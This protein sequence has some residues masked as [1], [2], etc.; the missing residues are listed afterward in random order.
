MSRDILKVNSL[1]DLKLKLISDRPEDGRVYNK[2][3]VSEV[4]TLIIG[5]IDY[6]SQ[7]DIITQARDGHLQRMDELHLSYLVYQYPL[8][9]SYGED[10]YMNNI[11][12][13]YKTEHLVPRKNR[14]IIKDLL[15]FRLQERNNEAKTLLFF[16]KIFQQ[17]LVDGYAMME[18]ERLIWLMKNQSK[19]RVRKYKNL[20]KQCESSQQ[21]DKKKRENGSCCHLLLWEARDI[22]NNFTFMVC[23]FQVS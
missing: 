6:G 13:K 19:L 17:F 23:L 10:G 4:A 8:I 21:C 7:R 16:F 2:H 18:S 11:L 20:Y 15:S 12:H 14:Q 1:L 22:W 9:F 5:D 3:T